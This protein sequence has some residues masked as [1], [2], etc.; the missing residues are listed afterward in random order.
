MVTLIL[1]RQ[2]IR[3]IQRQSNMSRA[4][5]LK[6]GEVIAFTIALTLPTSTLNIRLYWTSTTNSV[7]VISVN[8][9]FTLF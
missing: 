8:N 6:P 3:N 4:S 5:K 9:L 2:A 7:V 1:F